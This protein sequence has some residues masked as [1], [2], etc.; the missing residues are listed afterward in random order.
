[1]VKQIHETNPLRSTFT[2]QIL[3]L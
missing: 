3:S 2:W 1:M